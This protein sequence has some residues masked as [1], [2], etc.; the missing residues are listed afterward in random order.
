M[1]LGVIKVAFCIT[2]AAI[3]VETDYISGALSYIIGAVLVVSALALFN[4]G[5]RVAAGAASKKARQDKLN[6]SEN[7]LDIILGKIGGHPYTRG[8]YQE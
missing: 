2:V 1:L 5:C 4:A 6:T 3:V 7:A 8:P